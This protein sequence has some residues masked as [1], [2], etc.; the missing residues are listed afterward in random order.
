MGL[1]LMRRLLM[2]H[3]HGDVLETSAG[4]GR[5]LPYYPLRRLRSLTLTDTSRP[6]LVNAAD[7]YA[8]L[9]GEERCS[10]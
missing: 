4:T 8:A 7:K 2:R 6:M 9:A 5:N 1:R 10:G 3:A